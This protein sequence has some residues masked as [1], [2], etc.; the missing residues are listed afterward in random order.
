MPACGAYRN[1]QLLIKE[2]EELSIFMKRIKPA[3]GIAEPFDFVVANTIGRIELQV[4]CHPYL[5]TDSR[6]L[7]NLSV[8]GIHERSAIRL[9][10]GIHPFGRANDRRIKGIDR[11]IRIRGFI[12]RAGGEQYG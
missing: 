6:V 10:I 8:A 3:E 5:V 7:V 12:V 4:L 11:L 1:Q 2:T 9:A